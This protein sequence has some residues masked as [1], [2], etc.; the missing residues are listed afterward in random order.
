MRRSQY[1]LESWTSLCPVVSLSISLSLLRKTSSWLI[2]TARAVRKGKR[3][4]CTYSNSLAVILVSWFRNRECCSRSIA[5]LTL[6]WLRFRW[7]LGVAHYPCGS[8]GDQSYLVEAQWSKVADA[9]AFEAGLEACPW[10]IK[11]FLWEFKMTWALNF[12]NFFSP[13]KSYS[14]CLVCTVCWEYCS[15]N[16]MFSNVG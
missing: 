12:H 15:C 11:D 9:A 13:N 1:H 4:C 14:T 3:K 5:Y 6:L 2:N 16:D 8:L 10:W 7:G